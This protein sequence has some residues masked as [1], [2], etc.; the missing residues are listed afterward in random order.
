MKNHG[1]QNLRYT[2]GAWNNMCST[3]PYQANRIKDLVRKHG[4]DDLSRIW[5]EVEKTKLNDYKTH[6]DSISLGKIADATFT[7]V[8][9]EDSDYDDNGIITQGVKITTKEK[10][11]IDGAW[12]NKLHTTRTAI[13]NRLKNQKLRA[14]LQASQMGLGPLQCKLVKSKRGGKP[15]FDL[16]EAQ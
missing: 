11:N 9:V 3:S 1:T 15:Y 10:F 14:D 6:G 13:V 7:I 8:A 5:K 12:W 16:V 2:R 4:M